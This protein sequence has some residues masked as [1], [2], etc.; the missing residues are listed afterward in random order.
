MNKI[1][2][3]ILFVLFTSKLYADDGGVFIRV[4]GTT[5]AGGGGAADFTDTFTETVTV[6]L[7]LHT[8]GGT[9]WADRDSSATG[10][11][12]DGAT[13]VAYCGIAS[14]EFGYYNSYTPSDADYCVE[15]DVKV[16]G[17]GKTSMGIALRMATATQDQ[18]FVRYSGGDGQWELYK[19]VSGT[20][21]GLGTDYTGDVPTTVKSVRLCASSSSLTVYVAGVSRITATDSAIT[22]TGK[23]GIYNYFGDTGATEYIDNI[24]VYNT[25]AAP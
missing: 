22:A 3:L 1:S 12:D 5:A 17:S 7:S 10:I 20:V 11:S 19:R 8:E 25:V 14:D 2:A 4:K 15:G 16:S 18:Y 13:D 21:T 9:T 23:A 24:E 6:V